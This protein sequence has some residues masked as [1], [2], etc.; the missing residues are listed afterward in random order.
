MELKGRIWTGGKTAER[1]DLV[2]HIAV[3]PRGNVNVGEIRNRCVQK[4]AQRSE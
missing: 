1:F 4:L 2:H 3:D